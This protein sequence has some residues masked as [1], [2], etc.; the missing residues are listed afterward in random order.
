MKDNFFYM[1][2]K[3]DKDIDFYDYC[4][5][6]RNFKL[7]MHFLISDIAINLKRYDDCILNIIYFE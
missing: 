7:I 3:F 1:D 4:K 6:L 2:L 5:N